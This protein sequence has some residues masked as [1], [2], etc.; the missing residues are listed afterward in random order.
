M[1]MKE[2]NRLRNNI[3]SFASS[4]PKEFELNDF[5][6]YDL[7]FQKSFLDP[8]KGIS[9]KINWQLEETASLESFFG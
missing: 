4:F 5:I 9:D 2:P 6:D 1:Y 8:L 3:I 7:Q